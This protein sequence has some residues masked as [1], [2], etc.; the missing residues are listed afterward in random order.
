MNPWHILPL[1]DQLNWF[2]GVSRRRQQLLLRFARECR[3]PD[4]DL[5]SEWRQ[6]Y[7]HLAELYNIQDDLWHFKWGRVF[8]C[9][10]DPA[11]SGR[12]TPFLMFLCIRG[13]LSVVRYSSAYLFGVEKLGRY[14][15]AVHVILPLKLPGSVPRSLR[16]GRLD[17]A[18]DV[19]LQKVYL[20]YPLLCC[21]SNIGGK[22]D[23]TFLCYLSGYFCSHVVLVVDSG[24]LISK[25]GR[26]HFQDLQQDMKVFLLGKRLHW[27]VLIYMR[28]T[29]ANLSVFGVRSSLIFGSPLKV[30][31]Y[32]LGGV[33]AVAAPILEMTAIANAI[34]VANAS[35]KRETQVTRALCHGSA[36][37]WVGTVILPSDR[38]LRHRS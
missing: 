11:A 26:S 21:V 35:G 20:L 34:C 6:A 4:F 14:G 32:F 36:E 1:S 15:F 12:A 28:Y 16:V 25:D 3:V 23:F 33:C 9:F 37:P 31:K 38:T 10:R 7:R 19:S 29:D 5:P 27:Q 22:K 13:G 17:W 24:K 18:K 8:A 30:Y 2:K